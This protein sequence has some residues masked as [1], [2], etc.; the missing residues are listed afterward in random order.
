MAAIEELSYQDYLRIF[1]RRWRL[2]AVMAA[3]GAVGGL[4]LA[5]LQAPIPV[6]AAV[7]AVSFDPT[8]GFEVSTAA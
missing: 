5:R 4:V 7:A 3:A 6:Y 8:R 2:A 1:R